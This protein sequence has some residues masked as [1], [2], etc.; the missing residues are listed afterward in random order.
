MTLLT[1][2]EILEQHPELAEKWNAQKIGWLFSLGLVSGK[3]TRHQTIL[4]VE[5]VLKIY[6]LIK[7]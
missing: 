2:S 1:P 4:D 7:L 6:K 3:R 5:E